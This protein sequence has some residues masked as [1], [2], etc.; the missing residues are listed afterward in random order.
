MQAGSDFA[1]LNVNGWNLHFGTTVGYGESN[2]TTGT[3][4]IIAKAPFAG[5]YA[6]ATKGG[7]FVDGQIFGTYYNSVL[8]TRV[9]A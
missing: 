2:N 1:R 5:I 3:N 8:P 4:Q 6:A 7:F 9:S